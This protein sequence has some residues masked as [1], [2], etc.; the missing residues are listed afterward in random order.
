METFVSAELHEKVR[1]NSFGERNHTLILNANYFILNNTQIK[2]ADITQIKFGVNS[3]QFGMFPLGNRYHLSLKTAGQEFN[4]VLHSYWGIRNNYLVNLYEKLVNGI[5]L[6][7][8]ERLTDDA[9]NCLKANNSFVVG[10]CTVSRSGIKLQQK[11]AFSVNAELI[12]WNDL[13]YEVKYDRLV[14]NSKKDSRL[15]LNLYF[16]EYWNTEVLREVL[17]WLFTE[18]GLT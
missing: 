3:V 6:R 2:L 14:I 18:N 16:L 13:F 11:S 17:E 7:I 10:P 4:L 9:I 8:G 15:W 12:T 1:L 5:W